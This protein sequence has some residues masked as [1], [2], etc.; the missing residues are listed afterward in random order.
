MLR[1]ITL[2]AVL[3]SC[4]ESVPGSTEEPCAGRCGPNAMCIDEV[5]RCSE[6]GPVCEA[7]PSRPGILHAC[8]ADNECREE[9]KIANVV[10]AT[11]DSLFGTATAVGP[12]LWRYERATGNVFGRAVPGFSRVAFDGPTHVFERVSG[13]GPLDYEI[14]ACVDEACTQSFDVFPRL[15]LERR[16]LGVANGVVYALDTQNAQILSCPVSGCETPLV[17]ASDAPYRPH[18]SV[19]DGSG[20]Y[21]LML[22]NG[23]QTLEIAVMMSGDPAP[24]VVASLPISDVWNLAVTADRIFWTTDDKI[25]SCPK[26]SAPCTPATFATG[27]GINGLHLDASNVYWLDRGALM[28]CPQSGCT[29]PELVSRCQP[30]IGTV[31]GP[32]PYLLGGDDATLYCANFRDGTGGTVIPIAK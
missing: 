7:D 12:H 25:Q 3:A 32:L 26:S 23:T 24:S 9:I 6:T 11:T 16:L 5:C 27:V 19:V 14:D 15:P 20:I 31:V 2:I 4:S 1:A 29:S 13:F 8:T 17:R 18:R 30:D 28:R 21:M 10:A 22:D